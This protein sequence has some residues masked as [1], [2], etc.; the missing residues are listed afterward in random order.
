[1]LQKTA[2]GYPRRQPQMGHVDR[3]LVV[4]GIAWML[5]WAVLVLLMFV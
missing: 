2:K 4:A 5:V 1:M 3:F